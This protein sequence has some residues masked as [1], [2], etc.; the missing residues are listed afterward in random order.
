MGYHK[1]E[2]F[3]PIENLSGNDVRISKN[4]PSNADKWKYT[5]YTTL[6]FILISSPMVY[7]LT[8]SVTGLTLSV[9]GAPTPLGQ[10]VHSLI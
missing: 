2:A 9:D 5:L 10:I 6:L 1:R 3:A 7:Q 4:A 8:T